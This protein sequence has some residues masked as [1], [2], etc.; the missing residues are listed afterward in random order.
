[1]YIYVVSHVAQWWRTHLLMHKSQE[2]Q[3]RSLGQEDPLEE[4]MP[5]HSRILAWKIPWTEGPGG[6]QSARH[7]WVTE[8]ALTFILRSFWNGWVS[9]RISIL[10]CHFRQLGWGVRCAQGSQDWCQQGQSMRVLFPGGPARPG[11]P[12]GPESMFP[13]PLTAVS[14]GLTASPLY[15]HFL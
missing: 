4:G 14:L 6:P 9:A 11:H 15:A 3:V 2:M 8:H 1:M 12:Q 10:I 7:N 13:L 5:T